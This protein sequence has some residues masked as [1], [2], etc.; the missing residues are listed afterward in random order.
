MVQT[1]RRIASV[2]NIPETMTLATI[3]PVNANV[4][5]DSLDSAAIEVRTN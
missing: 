5:R 1:A 2:L 4:L 3:F